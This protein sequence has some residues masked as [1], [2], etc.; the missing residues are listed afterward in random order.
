MLPF[1]KSHRDV[2]VNNQRVLVRTAEENTTK[3]HSFMS[4]NGGSL[5]DTSKNMM[6]SSPRSQAQQQQLE[7]LRRRVHIQVNRQRGCLAAA[8][9][10]AFLICLLPLVAPL[11]CVMHENLPLMFF[12]SLCVHASLPTFQVSHAVGA[13]PYQLQKPQS[14]E[15]VFLC[16]HPC[17]LS[18]SSPPSGRSLFSICGSCQAS[19]PR[20]PCDGAAHQGLHRY[21]GCDEAYELRV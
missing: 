16:L 17:V 7:K 18:G 14:T 19:E 12:K 1:A 11:S 21:P 6:R 4:C 9:T 2:S 3:H 15:T 20:P 8:P 5:C 13:P 10:V